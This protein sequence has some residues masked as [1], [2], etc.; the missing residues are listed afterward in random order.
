MNSVLG[1]AYAKAGWGLP[2]QGTDVA[3][4]WD[5]LYWFLFWMSVFFFIL[6]VG[7]MVYFCF[8][9]RKR[10]GRKP[11]YIADHH[12]LEAFWTIVPTI[13]L[14]VIFG[15]GWSVY[16]KQI[17]APANAMEI[18]VIAKQWQ[19]TFQYD[20]GVTSDHLVV[21]INKPI[22][23]VMSS[24]DVLH[25]FFVPNFRVK[26]DVVPGMYTSVWFEARVPGEHQ[27]FCAEYC[28]TTHSGMLARIIVLEPAKYELWKAGKI[29]FDNNIKIATPDHIQFAATNKTT[30]KLSDTQS[31]AVTL[32]SAHIPLPEQGK[33]LV[34]AK[35]CVACHS[36]D[37]SSKIGPSY[38]G[39]FG[40]TT[41]LQDGSKV[42]VD[43]NYI[44]E[45]IER[46]EKKIVKGFNPVM[47]PYTKDMVSEE[48][49][50]AIIAYIK[51]LN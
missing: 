12:V 9:Y 5:H 29:K 17:S 1:K 38:K 26:Q 10:E 8:A 48:N 49:M 19:W 31:S 47:P 20:D 28:G 40:K 7:G 21:P 14:L 25:S 30:D 34:Q 22:K 16:K 11:K 13:L 15:W 37:G 27:V 32:A 23:L 43:E 45:S 24:Q 4:I 2:L 3:V 44:R 50:N 33:K 39:I 18:R 36:L 51:S 6:V 35:G 42:V 41:E 46:P